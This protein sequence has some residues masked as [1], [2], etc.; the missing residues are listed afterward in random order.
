MS[1]DLER[2]TSHAAQ[3]SR[4]VWLALLLQF[5]HVQVRRDNFAPAPSPSLACRG[6]GHPSHSSRP[7]HTCSPLFPCSPAGA[8][9]AGTRRSS[10][11]RNKKVRCCKRSWMICACWILR[12]WKTWDNEWQHRPATVTRRAADG[13][14]DWAQARS[15]CASVLFENWKEIRHQASLRCHE[16]LMIRDRDSFMIEIVSW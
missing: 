13:K 11:R 6:A 3:L 4:T 9:V 15:M 7:H 8:R 12:C 14:R 16:F 10:M 5:R 2:V 1:D